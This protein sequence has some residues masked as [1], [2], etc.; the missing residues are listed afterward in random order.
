MT[1]ITGEKP[2]IGTYRCTNCGTT[3]YLNDEND[4]LSPC[5]KCNGSDFDRV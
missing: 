4:T 5:P 2:G 1:H 3:V